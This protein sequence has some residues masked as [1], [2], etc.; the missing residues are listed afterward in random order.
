MQDNE[1]VAVV[2]LEIAHAYRLRESSRDA[3]SIR[4]I[5]AI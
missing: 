1:V 2:G 4:W 3:L 5:P